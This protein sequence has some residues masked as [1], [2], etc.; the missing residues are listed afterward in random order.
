MWEWYSLTFTGAATLM[1]SLLH[2][3]TQYVYQD[4]GFMGTILEFY[5]PQEPDW[6]TCFYLISASCVFLILL[7]VWLFLSR[8]VT[9]PERCVYKYYTV[10]NSTFSINTIS[11]K[12]LLLQIVQCFWTVYWLLLCCKKFNESIPSIKRKEI[13]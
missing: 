6:T 7:F 5:L 9:F 12:K 3:C 2:Y 10:F 1:K 8:I 11:L 4:V 13:W